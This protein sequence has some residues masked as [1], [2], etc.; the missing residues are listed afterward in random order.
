MIGPLWKYRRVFLAEARSRLLTH[1]LHPFLQTLVFV[2][3]IVGQLFFWQA[4]YRASDSGVIGGFDSRDMMAYLLAAC[5]VDQLTWA[6][7]GFITSD[8][9][10]GELTQRLLRPANYLK[11]HFFSWCA[12]LVP[13]WISAFILVGGLLLFFGEYVRL[14][15]DLWVY[16]AGLLAILTTFLLKYMFYCGFI[17]LLSFWTQGGVPL[18][19][20]AVNLFSGR[21]V[22][23]TFLPVAL[24]SVADVLPF[25]YMLYFPATVLMGHVEPMD[26]VHGLAVQLV[27]IGGFASLAQ[28]LWRRGIRHYVAFGG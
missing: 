24:Q 5:L 23:L 10:S 11:M 15:T 14:S 18:L 7:G 27:W 12:N 19:P 2:V 3:P 13:R 16:P 20:H 21:L 9:R 26:F 8:I 22:P 6:Y 25:R 28:L 4:V 1:R 17:S